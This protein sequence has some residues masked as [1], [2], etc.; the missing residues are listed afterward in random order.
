ME[1]SV[2]R[3]LITKPQIPSTTFIPF[4][5]PWFSSLLLPSPWSWVVLSSL[6]YIILIPL[7]LTQYEGGSKPSILL[8]L[9]PIFT[10]II[11][12]LVSNLPILEFFLYLVPSSSIVVVLRKYTSGS[13]QKGVME[14]VKRVLYFLKAVV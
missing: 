10:N 4:M 5:S 14:N 11:F 9:S 2:I 8:P 3:F 12:L 13:S 6:F 7:K 1:A